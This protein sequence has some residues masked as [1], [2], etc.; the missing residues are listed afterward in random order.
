MT[1]RGVL[2]SL[3]LTGAA[4]ALQGCVVAAAAPFAAAGVAIAKG[5]R[6]APRAPA[7]AALA[8]APSTAAA[9][10]S[11]D[12]TAV[13]LTDLT[14]LPAP[15][16]RDIGV[17]DKTFL[18]FAQH[19]LDRV[20]AS[21]ANADTR[22][23]VLATP[24]A[25]DSERAAC[26]ARPAMVLIDLDPGRDAFD[27]LAN[28]QT[29]PGL[30]DA[31]TRLR[32]QDVVIAWQTRLGE[33]FAEAIRAALARTGLDPEGTDK[34]LVLGSLDERKQTRRDAQAKTHCIVAIL[35]DERADF[36]ELYLYLKDREAVVPSDAIIGRGW[37]LATPIVSEG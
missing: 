33:N 28:S 17:R 11:S 25:F 2:S 37:F 27:P 29:D 14:A 7:N 22:S 19:A 12:D 21:P 3:A 35:G 8:P 10:P 30:V 36:D 26:R 16:P 34:L 6:D 15:S 13:V 31:L 24:G 18:T 23:A 4:F 32:E 20:E 1:L 9:L 5:K